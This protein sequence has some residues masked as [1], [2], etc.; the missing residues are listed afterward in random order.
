MAIRLLTKA[1]IDRAKADQ[2]KKEVDEGLKLARRVDNLR[3]VAAEEEASLSKF[4]KETVAKI[5]EELSTLEAKKSIL[6]GEIG[7][8]KK[9]RKELLKP[10]HEEWAL[11]H[12]EI[13]RLETLREDVLSLKTTVIERE[14]GTKEALKKAANELAK[15]ALKDER[16]T[17]LLLDADK[18]SREASLALENAREVEAKVLDKTKKVDQELAERD[19]AMAAK[20]RGIEMREKAIEEREAELEKEWA[21]L[22]DRKAMVERRIKSKK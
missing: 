15:A 9:E 13:A 21:K 20:E 4:R 17:E 19:M 18:A 3:E 1:E 12:R 16:A 10:L 22:D 6:V 7:Q 2:R 8:L 14:K 11:F 5:H